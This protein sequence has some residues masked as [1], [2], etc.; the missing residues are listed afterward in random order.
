[1]TSRFVDPCLILFTQSSIKDAFQNG[2]SLEETACQLAS[3]DTQKRDIQMMRVVEHTDGRAYSLDNRRLAVFRLLRLVGKCGKIKIMVIPKPDAEWRKKFDPSADHSK[4]L[5]RGPRWIVG[6]TRLDTTFPLDRI[7]AAMRDSVLVSDARVCSILEG[8]DSDDDAEDD[9]VLAGLR[10]RPARPK[11]AAKSAPRKKNA[12]DQRRGDKSGGN[13]HFPD[14]LE[15]FAAG[16]SRYTY[17]CRVQRGCVMGFPEGSYLVLKAFKPGFANHQITS[18]DVAMQQEVARLAALFNDN[19]QPKQNQQPCLIYVRDA[20]IVSFARDVHKQSTGKVVLP[21]GESFLLEREI[22][23]EFRKFNSNNGWATKT[24]GE[25]PQAFSHWTWAKYRKL[26]CDLQGYQGKP[27]GPKY[28]GSA[29]Y[30][31]FTDPAIM[32]I[33]GSYGLTD[34]GM[35]G[36]ENWFSAH[37]CSGM[38]HAL[39]ITADR[40]VGRRTMSVESSSSYRE[41]SNSYAPRALAPRNDLVFGLGSLREALQEELSDYDSDY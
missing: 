36:I 15:P 5:V 10:G 26:V 18:K 33:D 4:I 7:K 32:S 9:E 41:T 23:G 1:M 21:R 24:G 3:K 12:S 40:P 34:M 2:L 17:R 16:K 19:V 13:L 31:L 37:T 27:P 38:C 22:F 30:Y 35:R 14:D 25:I 11:Q 29:Y 20:A 8:M 28:L 39:G 6:A